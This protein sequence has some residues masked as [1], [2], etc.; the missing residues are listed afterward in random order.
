M[1]TTQFKI[2]LSFSRSG[3]RPKQISEDRL[4]VFT[5]LI[6]SLLENPRVR[7]LDV[8][9]PVWSYWDPKENLRLLLYKLLVINSF[10]KGCFLGKIS[11]ELKISA[12]WQVE[13]VYSNIFGHTILYLDMCW[14]IVD[15]ETFLSSRDLLQSIYRDLSTEA[16]G[17]VWL[18][19]PLYLTQ[20]RVIRSG[21]KG[22]WF[23]SVSSPTVSLWQKRKVENY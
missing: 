2:D 20:T 4:K 16:R 13:P 14:W 10:L 23:R 1:T 18:W 9:L 15:L 22:W 21:R 19:G 11:H 3:L 6:K 12:K 7:W 5:L 17:K 8:C